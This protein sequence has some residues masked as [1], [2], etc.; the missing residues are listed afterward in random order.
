M[1]LTKDIRVARSF[2][3]RRYT[4]ILRKHNPKWSEEKIQKWVARR[5]A[6]FTDKVILGQYESIKYSEDRVRNPLVYLKY[7]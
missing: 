7:D 6:K 5:D 1:K 2:L 3:N 4:K